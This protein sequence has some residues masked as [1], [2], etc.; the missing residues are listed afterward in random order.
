MCPDTSH[1]TRNPRP[2]TEILRTPDRAFADLP[3][4][5]FSPNYFEWNDIRM[6][7]LDEGEGD[8]V[9]LF[10]GE[11]TWSFLYRKV[12]PPLVAAGYRCIAPD[13]VGLGKSDKPVDDAFYT[14]DMHRDS[15]SALLGS[16]V[17]RERD[18]APMAR[19]HGTAIAALDEG[20]ITAAVQE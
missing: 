18:V 5:P 16:S 6:H 8:P 15:V 4:Y 17:Q 2:L 19:A 9:I 1:Q 20:G 3:D 14:F 12:I 10:H 13:Y 11:P 7:Y